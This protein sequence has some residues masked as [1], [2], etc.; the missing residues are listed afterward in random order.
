MS[1]RI[2]KQ[3]IKLDSKPKIIA[4]TSIV[5]PKEGDG[6]LKEYFD[7]VLQDD[8]DGK[9]SFEKA[10]SSIMYKAIEETIKKAKLTEQDINYLVAGD[11]LN[12]L[13]ASNFAARDMDIPFL[14][15]YGACSTMAES[16]SIASILIDGGYA[17]YAIA[18]TSSHFSSAERQ[19]RVPLE[20]G[21]QRTPTSQWTVTGSGAMLLAKEGNFPYT[22]YVTIGKIKDYG[23]TDT[24]DMGSAMAPAAVD[25][26]KQH[27]KDTGRTPNDYDLIAT[28]DLGSFGKKI[29]EELLKEYGYDIA[30]KYIDCGDEIFDHKRQKTN[31]GGSGCGCSAVV[32]CGYIYKNILCGKLKKILLVSTG[33]LMSPTTSLQGESIP[34]IAHAVSIEF[35]G[36][37]NE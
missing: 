14:G 30:N 6:P 13:S 37:K 8:L 17:N 21:S 33:A 31:C 24:N 34:G 20:M 10:E 3:T 7:I 23:K 1:K 28:G 27:L 11:L 19:F 12:Q 15:L 9:D 5:G 36:N 2:G 32:G 29:T 22:T 25:T 26:I 18:A 4:T 16:L 35:G